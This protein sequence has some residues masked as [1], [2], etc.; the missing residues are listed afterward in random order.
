[1][2][3]LKVV[4]KDNKQYQTLHGSLYSSFFN[5]Y[6][7]DHEAL[8]LYPPPSNSKTFNFMSEETLS[9]KKIRPP[10]LQGLQLLYPFVYNTEEFSEVQVDLPQ[11]YKASKEVLRAMLHNFDNTYSESL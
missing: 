10:H 7:T 5:H 1:M 3:L 4:P 2:S 11:W 6:N 9:N 8:N